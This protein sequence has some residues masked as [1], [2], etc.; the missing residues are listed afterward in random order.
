MNSKQIQEN[1][2]TDAAIIFRA[3]NKG[4][5]KH[6]LFVKINKAMKNLETEEAI[7]NKQQ[8]VLTE[9]LR[10][11]NY[12]WT[13]MNKRHTYTDGNNPSVFTD[14]LIIVV[15]KPFLR[16]AWELF[17]L[18]RV[19]YP[20][21]LGGGMQLLATGTGDIH[22]YERYRAMTI[23]NNDYHTMIAPTVS[24]SRGIIQITE[25]W[26]SNGEDILLERH[27]YTYEIQMGY[28]ML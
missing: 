22:G 10:Y 16:M 25:S 7:T 11:N 26:Q 5:N 20:N 19:R 15:K 12:G 13:I 17:A 21:C 4:S 6:T 14:G 1:R 8:I 23:R 18:I 27:I 2:P 3:H 24:L 28:V 9:L